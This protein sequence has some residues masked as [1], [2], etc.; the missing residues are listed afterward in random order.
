MGPQFNYSHTQR[1]RERIITLPLD[2]F[3]SPSAHLIPYFFLSLFYVYCNFFYLFIPSH[4]F[5]FTYHSF[6]TLIH[7]LKPTHTGGFA[8]VGCMEAWNQQCVC[9]SEHSSVSLCPYCFKGHALRD[10]HT[11]PCM[12]I[13]LNPRAQLRLM[14]MMY[15]SILVTL[16]LY[17]VNLIKNK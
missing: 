2:V 8:L 7:I 10:T 13:Q 15:V 17:R 14:P 6:Q 12:W 16:L 3:T 11:Q 4:S 9:I 5:F 1:E